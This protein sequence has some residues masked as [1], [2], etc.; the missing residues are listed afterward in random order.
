MGA[1]VYNSPLGFVQYSNLATLGAHQDWAVSSVVEH[2]LHT[3][4][5]TSSKLVPPTKD[6][7]NINDVEPDCWL[8]LI[9]FLVKVPLTD[10]AAMTARKTSIWRKFII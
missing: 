10:P 8:S 4:G 9:D 3:A 7:N 5:V 1:A 6:L 2:C